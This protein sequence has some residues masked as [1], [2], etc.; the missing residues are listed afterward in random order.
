[1]GSSGELHHQ[2]SSGLVQFP[3]EVCSVGTPLGNA[4]A[5]DWFAEMVEVA[6]LWVEGW[7][8]DNAQVQLLLVGKYGMAFLGKSSSRVSHLPKK[9]G[10]VGDVLGCF[11]LFPHETHR[12]A[13]SH[14]SEV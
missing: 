4:T 6:S 10:H 3:A 9:V 5:L 2:T 12:G 13:L 8:G 11:E 7:L 1:M 14:L